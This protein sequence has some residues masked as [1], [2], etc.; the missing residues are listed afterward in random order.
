MKRRSFVKTA[1]MSTLAIGLTGCR[2]VKKSHILTLSFDDGFKKSFHEIADI[3]EK[4]GLSACLNIISSGHLNQF[5]APNEYHKDIRGDFNDW[6]ALKRRGHEI[7]PHSWDHSHIARISLDEAKAD[8]EKGL[9][10]FEDNLEGYNAKDAVYNFAYNES[11]PELEQFALTKVR[12]IRTQGDTAWNPIPTSPARVRLGCWSFGPDNADKWVEEQVT[13]F[14]A[15]S[16]GWLI[17]NLH[18]LDAEGWGPVSSVYLDGLLNRMIATEYLEVLPAGEV[19][20][21]TSV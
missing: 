2:S 8:I 21:R 7:M 20:K 12:A 6:N 10:Y 1:V 17:L 13:N 11:T 15:S 5:A 4:Y 14:L 9:K 16:G 19:L 18:G 3:H